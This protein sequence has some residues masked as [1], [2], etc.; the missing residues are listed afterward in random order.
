MNRKQKIFLLI[1]LFL[2]FLICVGNYFYLSRGGMRLQAFCSGIFVLMG[3]INLVYAVNARD[4]NLKFNI[5]MAIG[6]VC[7]FLADM[8]MAADF[9]IGVIFFAVGH[10]CYLFAYCVLEKLA[11]VDFGVSFVVV[12]IGGSLVIASPFLEVPNEIMQWAG[13]IYACIISVMTGKAIANF[14]RIRNMLTKIILIGSVLFFFSDIML[15]FDWFLGMGSIMWIFCIGMYY[16]AQSLL[17]LSSYLS[18]GCDA[19]KDERYEKYAEYI[20]EI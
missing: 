7:A 10:I 11:R 4:K 3:I 15:V 18:V 20:D 2:V 19:E 12:C 13:L 17:A 6:L 1:N 8:T 5:M 9:I 14:V 16:P